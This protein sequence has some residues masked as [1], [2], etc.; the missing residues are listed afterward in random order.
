M[1][2]GLC[3]NYIAEASA[4]HLAGEH[5][6]E[7]AEAKLL[8]DL[9]PNV[10]LYAVWTMEHTAIVV[11]FTCMLERDAAALCAKVV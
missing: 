3:S 2:K 4:A 5:L 7:A 10:S 8:G 1:S 6:A 11:V 9:A